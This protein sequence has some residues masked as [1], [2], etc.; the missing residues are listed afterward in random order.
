MKHSESP[1][2]P[3]HI[4]TEETSPPLSVP[5]V[6]VLFDTVLAHSDLSAFR[7]ALVAAVGRE[8]HWLHNHDNESEQPGL[9]Y[10]YPL[11]Q[12]KLRG[13]QPQ[14]L[15]LGE[16]L[17]TARLFLDQNVWNLN[18]RDQ[19]R[20]IEVEAFEYRKY[21]LDLADE[22]DLR[23]RYRL[24]QWQALNQQNFARYCELESLRDI[25]DLLEPILVAQIL[26]FARAVGWHLPHRAV[27]RITDMYPAQQ[28]EYKG[29]RPTLFSL[30]FK[31]NVRLPDGIGLGKGAS[32]G[33][34]TVQRDREKFYRTE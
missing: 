21:P 22:G 15:C 10:R 6:R 2:S 4:H 7:G 33:F 1:E 29:I 13:H 9:Y 26:F 20:R 11:I 32:L 17:S 28:A 5:A 16:G 3:A 19:Q 23:Y 14:L 24:Y 30:G 31:S 27:V 12:Y 18:F 34:G 8:H 25:I